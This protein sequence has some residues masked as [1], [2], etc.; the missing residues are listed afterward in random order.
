VTGSFGISPDVTIPEIAP[1][2]SLYIK[3]LYQGIG[4]KVTSSEGIVGDYISYDWSAATNKLLASSY[5]QGTP[6]IF[7]GSLLPGLEKALAG[8]KFGSRVV[9]V[10]PPADAYGSAG[11][12]SQG[13]GPDD[14]LV[15]VVDINSA[16]D[17]ASVPGERRRRHAAHR[18]PACPW[19]YPRADDRDP[20]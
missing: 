18:N 1:P 4:A 15:F 5:A 10:M 2:S 14:S 11:S 3:T 6:S 12:K 20:S 17:T 19:Q 16:F 9:V 7:V 13:I 8:Q